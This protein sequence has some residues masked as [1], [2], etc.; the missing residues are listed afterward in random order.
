[1]LLKQGS[2]GAAVELL[3]DVMVADP[4]RWLENRQLPQ[5]EAWIAEQNRR[6][7]D[8]FAGLPYFEML[9]SR[10]RE[11]LDLEGQDQPARIRDCLFYR[12]RK[13]GQEQACICVRRVPDG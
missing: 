9:R 8:Y 10:V 5:T 7:E 13:Q 11:Y 4:Y 1:M 6:S 3:H 12:H 2:Q